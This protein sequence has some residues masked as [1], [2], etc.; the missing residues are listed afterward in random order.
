MS[1]ISGSKE[2]VTKRTKGMLGLMD[3]EPLPYRIDSQT[4][5]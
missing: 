2:N 3:L 4:G 1:F 5:V